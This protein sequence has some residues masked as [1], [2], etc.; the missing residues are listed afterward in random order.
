MKKL[1]VILVVSSF[2]V[3]GT[4][5]AQCAPRPA[6]CNTYY[7]YNYCRPRVPPPCP[8]RP[9]WNNYWRRPCRPRPYPYYRRP[10]YPWFCVGSGP[11]SVCWGR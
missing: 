2:L 1:V 6:G 7:T 8:P 9:C 4:A 5:L 10:Y 11:F 3:T